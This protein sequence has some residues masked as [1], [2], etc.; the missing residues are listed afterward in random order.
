[1]TPT[2]LP[3]DERPRALMGYL[4]NLL[5]TQVM[6][7]RRLYT[8]HGPVID[9]HQA[10]I[11]ERMGF[12]TDRRERIRGLVGDGHASAFEI[13]RR[14]WS[15]ETVAASPV[16]VVWEVLGHLDLL[17][18]RGMVREEIDDGGRHLFR[19]KEAAA[20]RSPVMRTGDRKERLSE[21]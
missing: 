3:G 5:R 19:P 20:V 8:G 15:E 14:L 21:T 13:A 12:H 1:M 17:I 18:N 4:G 2:E 7:L 11:E 16:L 9:D 6:P 10:L